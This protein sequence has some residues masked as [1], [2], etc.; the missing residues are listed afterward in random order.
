MN[1]FAAIPC[2]SKCGIGVGVGDGEGDA[3]SANAIAKTIASVI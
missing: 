1:A 2:S 3:S